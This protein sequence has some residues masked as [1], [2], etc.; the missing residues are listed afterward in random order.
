MESLKNRFEAFVR[1]APGFEDVD[2]LTK[3][4]R[5]PGRMKAD[6]LLTNRRMIIE[7]KFLESDPIEKAQKF[8]DDFMHSRGIRGY[9]QMGLQ[10]IFR[11]YPDAAELNAQLI[12]KVTKIVDDKC[13]HADKQTRHTRLTFMIP[14]AIGL[15]V[16]LN[17]TAGYLPPNTVGHRILQTL[18]KKEQGTARYAH[19]DIALVIS[20]SHVIPGYS[21][22]TVLPIIIV[23]APFSNRQTRAIEVAN[24][25]IEAWAAFN[26]AEL[27]KPVSPTTAIEQRHPNPLHFP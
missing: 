5:L 9:G 23:P 6:Y 26:G 11:R 25:V 10:A 21:D 15:L 2:Q 13:A 8:L 7:Q 24:N 3:G 17:E 20:E 19:N 27:I 14:D 4:D 12:S 1:A 16:F 18:S 22:K